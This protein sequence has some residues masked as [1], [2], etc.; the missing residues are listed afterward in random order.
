M[1]DRAYRKRLV[2]D[3]PKW[4]AEGWVT[5]QGAG[6]ILAALP[7]GRA[8]FGIVGIVATLG[9]L[10]LGLSVIAFVGANWDAIPRL[11]RFTLLA[12]A[13][14]LAYVVAASLERR[15]LHMFSEAAMLVAGLIFA[16]AIALVG[17]SY[18]LAGDFSGAVLLWMIGV[19]AA[20]LLTGSATMTVLGLIGGGYWSWMAVFDLDM[21]PHWAGLV[22]ILV[23][24]AIATVIDSRNTRILAVLALIYWLGLSIAASGDRYDWSYAGGMALGVVTGLA[25]FGLGALLAAL[26]NERIAALGQAMLWPALAV[27]VVVIG[28]EQIAWDPSIGEQ[29]LLTLTVAGIAI[30]VALAAA[31]L[32]QK[33]LSVVDVGAVA[34]IGLMALIFAL[35][36]PESDF[37]RRLAGGVMV[38]LT[39]LW[40]INLGQSGEVPGA[41]SVGLA[42]LGIEVVYLYVATLGGLF[43]TAIGFLLGGVLLIGLAWSLYKLD[44]F[45]SRRRGDGGGTAASPIAGE[46]AS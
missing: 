20:A 6:A 31:A 45:L 42:A 43:Y 16:A 25:L 27:V 34:L 17:Q 3:L 41:K 7:E 8:L 35:N 23:G 36:L 1:R 9:G 19:F 46:V 21:G 15:K 29:G 4:Q 24:G 26:P 10:L 2:A 11:M 33:G 39:A 37:W 13:L 38:I 28:V 14:A 30:A 22:P 5:P 32:W 44:R 18:H 40:L 12:M